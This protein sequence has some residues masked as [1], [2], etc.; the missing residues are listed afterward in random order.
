MC[1]LRCCFECGRRGRLRLGRHSR[2]LGRAVVGFGLT[3]SA[4]MDDETKPWRK[5]RRTSPVG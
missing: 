4:L 5:R 3:S 1:V 2:F